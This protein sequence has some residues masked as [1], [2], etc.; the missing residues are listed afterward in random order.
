MCRYN[1]VAPTKSA[2][3]GCCLCPWLIA[4]LGSQEVPKEDS[5]PPTQIHAKQACRDFI[6]LLLAAPIA[7]IAVSGSQT[8]GEYSPR[9]FGGGGGRPSGTASC[10][11]LRVAVLATPKAVGWLAAGT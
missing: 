10:V 4:S 8:R 6:R 11:S 3:S 5:P 1:S 9:S 2:G 7:A